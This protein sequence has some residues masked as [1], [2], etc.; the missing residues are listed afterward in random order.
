M[1]FG[2]GLG[3]CPV[4][5]MAYKASA[6]TLTA[7][8]GKEAVELTLHAATAKATQGSHQCGQGQ[9]ARA[10][11]RVGKFRVPG[12]SRKSR[13]LDVFGQLGQNGLYGTTVLRQKSCQPQ[14]KTN[15]INELRI[16]LA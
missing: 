5:D 2:A 9:L 14:Q 4:G 15:K 12:L 3:K 13:A 1:Q 7:L 11:E 10:G 8:V 16:V 6:Y